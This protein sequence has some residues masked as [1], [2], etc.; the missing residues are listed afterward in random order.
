MRIRDNIIDSRFVGRMIRI[1]THC[2]KVIEGILDEVTRYELGIRT[3]TNAIVVM[4]HSIVKVAVSESDIHGSGTIE[5]DT[6]I[7][8]DFT[9]ENVTI[10]LNSCEEIKGR[11]MKL[12][13]YEVGVVTNE[14]T[15]IIPKS[16]II[17]VVLAEFEEE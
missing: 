5:A 17:Y 4:R 7:T 3:S 8:N 12:S 14:G 2:G 15:Y 6:V 10:L 1:H 9:G 11:L 13:K 16:A